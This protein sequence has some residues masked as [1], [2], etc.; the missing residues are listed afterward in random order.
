[1]TVRGG[2]TFGNT[3]RSGLMW[4]WCVRHFA[5]DGQVIEIA[6][7]TSWTKKQAQA[8]ILMWIRLWMRRHGET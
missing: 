8:A 7:G 5:E 6:H 3:W 2:N 4:R 1:M